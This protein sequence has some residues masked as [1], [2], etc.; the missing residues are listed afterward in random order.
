MPMGYFHPVV[1]VRGTTEDVNGS[2]WD[3]T[4]GG[5]YGVAKNS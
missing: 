1:G 5:A 2:C 3:V 4:G